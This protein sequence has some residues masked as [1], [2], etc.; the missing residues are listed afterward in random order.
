[1]KK[2][3]NIKSMNKK[4]SILVIGETSSDIWHYGKVTRLAPDSPH[5]I[6]KPLHTCHNLGMAR[7]VVDSI[8]LLSNHEYDVKFHSQLN[9]LKKERYIDE[10]SNYILLRVDANDEILT[11]ETFLMD[12][13]IRE[14]E[15]V[16]ISDYN[17]GFLDED[18]IRHVVEDCQR[19][20]IPVFVDTKKPLGSFC[21]GNTFV[22]INKKEYDNCKNTEEFNACE[23]KNLIITLGSQGAWYYSE[24]IT[25]DIK[26]VESRDLSGLGDLA[27]SA[28]V[29]RYLETYDIK[30]SIKFFNCA[31]SIAA[32]HRGIYRPSRQEVDRVYHNN[33]QV[34][35]SN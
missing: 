24:D 27:L 25:F 2:F 8:K 17:K 7:N 13:D 12:E 34:V 28:L 31:C 15:A 20:N 35:K 16:V 32:Q 21:C 18:D 19:Y 5:P 14:Y 29:V 30:E 11:N 6:F 22:K 33:Q 26:K 10:E 1:M 3:S 4:K 23:W 9:F